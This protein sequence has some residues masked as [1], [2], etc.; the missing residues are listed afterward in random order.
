[1]KNF[2]EKAC[3]ELGRQSTLL[4]LQAKFKECILRYDYLKRHMSEVLQMITSSTR[5]SISD[6]SYAVR[7]E[8]CWFQQ[9]FSVLKQI[10]QELRQVVV[11]SPLS[12]SCNFE[13]IS[14]H[15]KFRL[16]M[17]KDKN[18]MFEFQCNCES[19]LTKG[20]CGHIFFRKHY[21][22]DSQQPI[23]ACCWDN[24]M[25][26]EGLRRGRPRRSAPALFREEVLM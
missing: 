20:F 24:S 4:E 9:K 22:N 23:P 21:R 6:G 13:E 17:E 18:Y 26:A 7:N 15:E 1:M 10:N 3:E 19:A 2:K 14:R 8:K 25:N 16:S 12:R 11:V 5:D